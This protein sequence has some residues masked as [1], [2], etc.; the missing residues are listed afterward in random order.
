MS[1]QRIVFRVL[2]SCWPSAGGALTARRSCTPSASSRGA[3]TDSSSPSS[4]SVSLPVSAVCQ[5][6]RSANSG[7]AMSWLRSPSAMC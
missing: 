1:G 7:M 2:G 4:S 5:G 3:S 6:A